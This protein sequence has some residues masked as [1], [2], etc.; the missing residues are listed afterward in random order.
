M[1]VLNN[2]PTQD[3]YVDAL[4]L[5]LPEAETA[6]LEIYNASVFVSLRAY[7]ETGRNNELPWG[8]D[9]LL[10][11]TTRSYG[12]T[13]GIRFRSGVAGSPARVSARLF[14]DGDPSP[15][16]GT[17]LDA[18]L[19][20][21][22]SFSNP[23]LVISGLVLPFA[24]A[25]APTGYVLCDGTHYNSVSD[26]TFANLF[27]AIG[28]TYGGTGSNDFAVPDLRG[29]MVAGVG[30]QADVA[31]LGNSEGSAVG[32]RRPKHPHTVTDPGHQHG[33]NDPGHSHL[34]GVLQ[35]EGV[36][37]SGGYVEQQTT[38]TGSTSG[39]VAA[40]T[41]GLS[42]NPNTAN[43][44]VGPAGTANDA[45]AYLVLNYVIAK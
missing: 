44:S 38:Q 28:T 8:P 39:I 26:P 11:P 21:N 31:T 29:R 37:G 42:M 20:A 35:S 18:I 15:E 16:G 13:A 10:Q 41:T 24:G 30:T 36:A 9:F 4:T 14:V 5:S 23:A 17:P 25:A 45:P 34:L 12:N 32:N 6:E 2:Q 40:N 19:A 22:G 3:Q 43:I 33:L 27:A 1:L 7:D